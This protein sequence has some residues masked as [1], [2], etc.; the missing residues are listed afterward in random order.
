MPTSYPSL[1]TATL[2][3]YF[4]MPSSIANDQHFRLAFSLLVLAWIKEK[5]RQLIIDYTKSL[6]PND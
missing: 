3:F 6:F 5:I 1:T 4:I 2:T